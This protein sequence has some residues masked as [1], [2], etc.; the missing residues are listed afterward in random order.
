[1]QGCKHESV[2]GPVRVI[3][4]GG[5]DKV[6]LSEIVSGYKIISLESID[7]SLI[8]YIDG[9]KIINDKIYVLDSDFGSNIFVFNEDGSFV[10]K[11]Q[12][13]GR[14][15]GEFNIP[16]CFAVDGSDN[17]YVL[18]RQMAR[19][20]KYDLES[21][22]YIED[23]ILPDNTPFS[24]T[25][26]RKGEHFYYYYSA[27][28]NLQNRQNNF[29]ISNK[30]GEI[31]NK[32]VF[33]PSE[34]YI[35]GSQVLF[36]EIEKKIYGY[37]LFSNTVYH[38]D[39]KDILEQYLFKFGDS[40]FPEQEFFL[41]KSVNMMMQEIVE[42]KYIRSMKVLESNDHILV[43]YDIA[44][45]NYIGI[46]NKK[47]EKTTNIDIKEIVDD[48]GLGVQDIRIISNFDDW[49]ISWCSSGNYSKNMNEDSNPVLV[50]FKLK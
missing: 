22:N 12:N 4:F 26:D 43:N 8:G 39:E 11:F 9:L 14:G 3:D 10:K 34:S 24:F 30:K 40:V 38:M 21:F 35:M 27:N 50:F 5:I 28:T 47:N 45:N 17:L 46:Y 33:V 32:G 20:L 49:F 18:D 15:P 2:V 19:L 6:K 31:L 36:Y 44:R 42:K 23:I 37:P 16:H 13:K 7:E 1:M 29:I 25:V 48:I 41:N